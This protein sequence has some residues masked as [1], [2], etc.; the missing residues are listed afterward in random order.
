MTGQLRISIL[1]MKWMIRPIWCPVA[2]PTSGGSTFDV[3]FE[4]MMNGPSRGTCS[5]PS[6]RASNSRRPSPPAMI[7][8]GC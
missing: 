3:W 8:P 4:T 1:A 6:T 2:Q 7:A 5:T